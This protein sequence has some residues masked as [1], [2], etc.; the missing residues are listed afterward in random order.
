[1]KCLSNRLDELL[2][3]PYPSRKTLDTRW[4]QEWEFH[5]AG[6][7]YPIAVNIDTKAIESG[8]S[9]DGEPS[10]LLYLSIISF[11]TLDASGRLTHD[12]TGRGGAA[13]ILATIAEIMV[14][15]IEREE[16]EVFLFT[17]K[18]D[19][20][21]R[22]YNR[23]AH[24]ITTT[25]PYDRYTVEDLFEIQRA[26]ALESGED[27]RWLVLLENLVFEYNIHESDSELFFFIRDDQYWVNP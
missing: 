8:E 23:F 16:P 1:M 22:V 3:N 14:G 20:R 19:S 24:L 15:W 9:E 2:D 27:D 7:T 6:H 25:Y 21:K 11:S 10:I 4:A 5:P 12:L 26:Y 18:E 13:R 17:A